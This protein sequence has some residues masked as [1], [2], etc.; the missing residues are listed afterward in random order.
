MKEIKFD[1]SYFDT[2]NILKNYKAACNPLAMAT[3]AMLY[4]LCGFA[5]SGLIFMPLANISILAYIMADSLLP[6]TTTLITL[7]K[8]RKAKRL[9]KEALNNLENIQKTF[10]EKEN[11]EVEIESLENSLFPYEKMKKYKKDN[12]VNYH[13]YN[14]F[15]DKNQQVQVLKMYKE[16]L[17]KGMKKVLVEEREYLLD[18]EDK[19]EIDMPVKELKLKY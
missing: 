3:L 4:A 8:Y 16:Y 15:L 17:K 19:K 6:I 5:A 14:Y 2:M 9:Y 10:K 13:A 18:E 1:K 11:I 12:T 7:R